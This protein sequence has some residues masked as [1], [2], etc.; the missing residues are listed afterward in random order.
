MSIRKDTCIER[1]IR[2]KFE[3]PFNYDGNQ[4][5]SV[6]IDHRHYTEGCEQDENPISLDV[7]AI[8][9]KLT[10]NGKPDRREKSGRLSS[11]GGAAHRIAAIALDELG[12]EEELAQLLASEAIRISSY[13]EF[14]NESPD[15][16]QQYSIKQYAK[17]RP[18]VKA[19]LKPAE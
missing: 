10:S 12:E 19:A 2:I 6:R 5:E 15:V 11:C 17:L 1:T 9:V 14:R 16:V 7:V 13:L 3:T 8:G 18:L 4:I